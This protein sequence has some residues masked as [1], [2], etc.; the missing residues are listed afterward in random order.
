MTNAREDNAIAAE[1]PA[2]AQYLE[3]ADSGEPADSDGFIVPMEPN[4]VFS[5]L[6]DP[7]PADGVPAEL[8][9]LLERAFL[10]LEDGEWA[11]ADDY[12]ERVL[13]K[14]PRTAMAYLGKFMAEKHVRTREALESVPI[15]LEGD[16]HY[17][18]AVR[19]AEPD[20]A[21]ALTRYALTGR[22]AKKQRAIRRAVAA[23]L[24]TLACC[25]VLAGTAAAV[26]FFKLLPQKTFAAELA[27][28]ESAVIG[29]TV[30][31]GSSRNPQEWLVL[32]KNG[33]DVLLLSRRAV[34]VSRYNDASTDTTWEKSDIRA[35]LNGAYYE[36]AFGTAERALLRDTVSD[37]DEYNSFHYDYDDE[38][39]YDF[40]GILDNGDGKEIVDDGGDLVQMSFVPGSSGDETTDKLFLL[41]A[42]E[43]NL[44]LKTNGE[45]RCLAPLTNEK[46]GE[47]AP[48]E[49]IGW[50]LRTQTRAGMPACYI[51]EDG[52]LQYDYY[53]EDPELGVRPAVWVSLNSR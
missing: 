32:E 13:D 52:V 38:S 2:G 45:K 7:L 25:A 43:V 20:L 5:D 48:E 23:V 29:D 46:T 22:S 30:T 9:P 37:A 34:A 19:F 49:Y 11:K 53:G 3:P 47:E 35:W 21:D 8:A 15:D 4:P 33:D 39:D 27:A 28:L 24:I 51:D 14:A 44:R 12:C 16:R 10:F 50:W 1:A 6:P 31:F 42:A 17:S 36:S 18:K 41:N 26:W 40:G